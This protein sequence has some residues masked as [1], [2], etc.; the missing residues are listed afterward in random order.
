MAAQP[1]AKELTNPVAFARRMKAEDKLKQK[2]ML[3][4][5]FLREQILVNN[6]IDLLMTEVLDF[7]VK[8]F[9]MMMWHHRRV[10]YYPFE[11]Q[12]WHLALAPR[13]GGKTTI[14]TIASI[15]LD[16]LQNPNI[17][18]LIASKT[19]SNAVG[20]LSEIKKKLESK[21][22][23][24][25]FGQQ[26]GE[27][28]NDGTI[29]VRPR[30]ANARG[31][32]VETVGV[33]S[34]LASRH[35][36][37]IYADDLVDEFNSTTEL[38]REKIIVW[39][40]KVLDPTLVPSGEMSMIGTRYHFS[41]LWG[42]M[43][44]RMFEIR[45]KKQKVIRRHYIR[46]PALMKRKVLPRKK[47]L[48][49]H[50]K[51]ISFWP[52]RFTVKFLLKKWKKQGSI[53]FMSQYMNDVEGMKGKIFQLDWF[54]WYKVGDI[55]VDDLIIFQGVDLAIKQKETADK[56]AHVTIGVH[57]KTRNIY[58]L[59]YYNRVT[60]YNK[61]KKVIADKFTQYDPVRVGI[62]ANGY[63]DA[64]RQDMKTSPDDNF[65]AVRA[66]P[67]YTDTDKTLR[68][69]KLSAYFERGQVFFREGMHEI[70]Q[71]LLKMPDGRYKDLFDALDIAISLA[72]GT[73]RKT[74][75]NE[76]GLI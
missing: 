52:E 45:N 35:F 74:R 21:K 42:V 5:E 24:D 26:K 41:D 36:D 50:D 71:H 27:I 9:H 8:D 37:K 69:W 22:L 14:L 11:S 76:P 25:I 33:G 61:Q 20:F 28:W 16:I 60:H 7:E 38:Q 23:T 15:V 12:K 57:K 55:N 40:D 48:K 39:F 53:V 65:A 62:E 46:I 49:K 63:Q 64:L 13:G 68:A 47:K 72:F 4:K 10:H 54:E 32:T 75:D 30:E 17:R 3:R 51:Y 44:T 29:T 58:V 34:A 43:I 1:L 31:K 67:I 56:F 2:V 18:I 70:Q 73:A 66:R 6:R 19:D 59:N